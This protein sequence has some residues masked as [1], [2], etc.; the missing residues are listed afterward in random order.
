MPAKSSAG[1]ANAACPVS[2]TKPHGNIPCLAQ[3]GET[4]RLCGCLALLA[5]HPLA[6]PDIFHQ[7]GPTC[8]TSLRLL[9]QLR[10]TLGND[11]RA[12]L[13]AIVRHLLERLGESGI[14]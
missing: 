14:I 3:F 1:A 8:E 5:L 12:Q 13:I 7:L 11:I 6:P 2:G 4:A 10:K 9:R